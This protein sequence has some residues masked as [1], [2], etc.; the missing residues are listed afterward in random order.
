MNLL[1]IYDD[2][3][4]RRGEYFSESHQ[5]LINKLQRD[6]ITLHQSLNTSKCLEKSVDYYTSVFDGQPFIF[7]AYTHGSETSI[8][9]SDEA[10]IHTNNAYLFN[11]TLFYACCCL[12][13]QSLGKDLIA[14]GCTVFLGFDAT[15][16]SCSP[17]TEGIFQD[18]ENTFIEHFLNTESSIAECMKK[19]NEKYGQM[20]QHISYHSPFEAGILDKNFDSFQLL[21]SEEAE[22]F[23]KY[24]FM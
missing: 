14:N 6:N 7:V 18:C 4:V 17:E 13:A 20:I 15:I 11:K 24:D 5:D 9:V 3:D 19:M 2:L 23:T 8:Q 16:T 10:Y 12:S 22:K 1:T 21:C